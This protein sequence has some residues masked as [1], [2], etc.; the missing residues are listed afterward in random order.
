VSLVVFLLEV[1]DDHAGLEQGVPV[2]AVKA[3]LPE[4]VVERFD[5]AVVPRT[6]R[7]NV[8]HAGLVL[9]EPLQRLRNQLCPLSIRSTFGGPPATANTASNSAT[10]RSAVIDRSTMFSSEQRVCS[11]IIEAILTAL[12][13]VVEPN[14]KSIAHTTF[15]GISLD[16]RDRG[17]PRPLSRTH[18]FDL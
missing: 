5:V 13:S 4:S 3:L 8:D 18:H 6:T 9:A 1:A 11:S 7:R 15:G 17:H 16:R 10:S 2:V 12:P 14:W